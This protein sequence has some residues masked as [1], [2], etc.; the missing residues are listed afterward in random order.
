VF[1]PHSPRPRRRRLAA[2]VAGLLLAAALLVAGCGSSGAGAPPIPSLGPGPTTMFT[3]GSLTEDTPANLDLLKQLGVERVHV[4]MH[5][6]DIAPDPNSPRRPAFA[7]TRPS[8]YPASGWA[9]YDAVVRSLAAR[10]LG[11]DLDL[12]APPPRWGSGPGAPDPATQ[13]FW[14]PSAAQFGLFVQA[15]ARRYSGSYTPPG[16]SSP[17]PRVAFWSIWN[18]PN[19]GVEI[20]P[21]AIDH[22]TIEVAPR[23]YR[24]LV[25]A[26]WHAFG[27]TGHGHD[28]I[29]IGE[30]APAGNTAGVGP[31]NFNSMAPLRFLR[32]LY[33]V[34][35]DYR[36]LRG[37]AATERGCPPT[38]AGSARFAAE[39]PGL[40]HAS[41]FSDHPY[42]QGLPP[43]QVTPGEPDFAELAE[44]G[45]LERVLDEMQRDYGSSTRFPIW[46]T[47]FGYQTAPPDPQPG[48][49]NPSLAA[50]YLNQAEYMTWRDPRIR[51]YD[52]YLLEDPP[53]G[54][55]AFGLLSAA[56]Q[57]KPGFYAFRMPIWLPVRTG[58]PGAALDVW[59]DVRAAGLA[60]HQT[61][62]TQTVLIQF[63]PTG[64]SAF[65]TVRQV[66]LTS[67]YGYFDVRQHFA[68]SGTVR[69]KWTNPM[70]VAE[71]S[72]PVAITLK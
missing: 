50:A 40:F 27:I 63:A 11:I 18:E 46:S 44:I 51:S 35:A 58:S 9:P 28:T 42:P 37:T 48:S 49:V 36:P 29:L 45:K 24:G 72:R 10:H 3:G 59:G 31:G 34:D 33:C 69:T 61:H 60:A 17:L 26:A 20:A 66:P 57:P 15:V 32:A 1:P 43:D 6:A 64:S 14:H 12:V 70:G 4:Y 22:S 41:G 2:P 65:R 8:A 7:A 25:D 5:W 56:G 71:Y 30:M 19:L 53:N 62:R 67:P 54:D 16:Q 21:E 13:P 23:F 47:E 55:Y 52:Q 38:A 39:N 68:H